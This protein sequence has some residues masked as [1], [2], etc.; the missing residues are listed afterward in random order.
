MSNFMT[1][2]RQALK[3]GF[4]SAAAMALTAC[5]GNGGGEGAADGG[6]ASSIKVGLICLHDDNSTYDLNFINGFKEAMGELGVAEA[7]PD[8]LG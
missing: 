1:N 5:G 7:F 2:R 3:L 8:A 4:G 6:D